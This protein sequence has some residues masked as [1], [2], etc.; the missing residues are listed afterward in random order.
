MSLLQVIQE[1]NFFQLFPS[2]LN[3]TKAKIKPSSSAQQTKQYYN[4]AVQD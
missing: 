3:Y 2:K 4:D 1:L